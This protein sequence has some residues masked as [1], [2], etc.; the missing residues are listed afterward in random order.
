M[1]R[2]PMLGFLVAVVSLAFATHSLSTH[3]QHV[4]DSSA[5]LPLPGRTAVSTSHINADSLVGVFEGRTPCGV[6]AAD[7]T[8]FPTRNCEKIKWRLTLYRDATT[9][10]PTTYTFK[11]TRMTRQG[12]WKIEGVAGP[13]R[14]RVIFRL[15]YGMPAKVLSL[16][17]VDDRVLLL[18]DRNLNVLIGDASWSYVL[19]RTDSLPE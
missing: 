8:G 15:Q 7:F 16:L 1:T 2:H 10:E 12:S 3:A 4:R 17:S 14:N 11:G 19:N 6:I 5:L 13:K 18:L 9:G